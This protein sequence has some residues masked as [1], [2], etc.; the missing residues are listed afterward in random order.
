MP[1]LA[2]GGG[3]ALVLFSVMFGAQSGKAGSAS[4]RRVSSRVIRGRLDFVAKGCRTS[5]WSRRARPA[6]A[7]CARGS[8]GALAGQPRT[9]RN[10]VI[11]MCGGLR[12]VPP[13]AGA[14]LRMSHSDDVHVMR[15]ASIDDEKRKSPDR[16][17]PCS[18]A[19]AFAALREVL[20]HIEDLRD[21]LEELCSPTRST[22]LVPAD[23]FA[24]F[25]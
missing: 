6:L 10:D 25:E 12:T 23:G 1:A 24:E 9:D 22:F 21:R 11:W 4:W 2:T 5:K 14:S 8:F 16:E 13:I 19:P 18:C 7:P 3:H 17:L 15:T 20:D